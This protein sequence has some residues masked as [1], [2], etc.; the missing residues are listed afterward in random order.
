[1]KVRL[2]DTKTKVFLSAVIILLVAIATVSVFWHSESRQKRKIKEAETSQLTSAV[3]KFLF[4][5]DA[6]FQKN[7]YY[8]VNNILQSQTKKKTRRNNRT[9]KSPDVPALWIYNS[10]DQLV[11]ITGQ[12]E[13]KKKIYPSRESIK[14]LKKTETCEYYEMTDRGL[15][16]I[17]G[18]I[19]KDQ[20]G[21]KKNQS[22]RNYYFVGQLWDS[23]FI[24]QI[25]GKINAKI[26]IHPIASNTIDLKSSKT[27]S[28]VTKQLMGW[29]GQNI[30]VIT[31]VRD[32]SSM[33]SASVL[34]SKA[35]ILVISMAIFI[36]AL[37]LTAVYY[38]I[39]R[40]LNTITHSIANSDY[41]ELIKLMQNEDEF[42]EIA[43]FINKVSSRK[44]E[45]DKSNIELSNLMQALTAKE[46]VI[47]EKTEE[48]KKLTI[49][50][51]DYK[52]VK[53]ELTKSQYKLKEAM[54][55]LQKEKEEAEKLKIIQRN[56][57]A[58]LVADTKKAEQPVIPAR[59][60]LVKNE[61]E[62]LSSQNIPVVK[63]ET[64][65][66]ENTQI[67]VV[68]EE[69]RTLYDLSNVIAFAGDRKEVIQKSI[70][71][72]I[73][74]STGSIEKIKQLIK[75]K[76]FEQVSVA[77]HNLKPSFSYLGIMEL[78][79]KVKNIELNAKNNPDADQLGQ[80]INTVDSKLALVIESLRREIEKYEQ[81][82][83][84]EENVSEP[85]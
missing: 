17:T 70:L 75:D 32:L 39:Y 57:A 10:K 5:E 59:Q 11:Y 19:S 4:S 8:Q 46:N 1:M 67:D 40:P 62:E 41:E 14:Q 61:K 84:K 27:N 18:Y 69:T 82:K 80:W 7:M 43:T 71:A 44:E 74:Q 3:N 63:A 58:L 72:F 30:A 36:L 38:L 73:D 26:Y 56:R 9:I 20:S 49:Q 60:E 37:M 51:T 6:A 34:S 64:V 45:S 81:M 78:F 12:K 53:E 68:S 22:S 23:A 28:I 13:L 48:I 29:N 2:N 15:M 65:V 79:E 83:V 24:R 16:K 55:A 47:T 33:Q 52:Q 21:N 85:A 66:S 25:E 31:A 35:Y 54:D 50:Q 76:D 42:G 77:A